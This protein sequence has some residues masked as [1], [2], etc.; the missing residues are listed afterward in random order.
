MPFIR[1]AMMIGIFG[2]LVMFA[3]FGFFGGYQYKNNIQMNGTLAQGYNSI[4]GNGSVSGNPYGIGK[5]Q[6][7]AQFTGNSLQ[8]ATLFSSLTL[9]F[10][11]LGLA[12]QFITSIPAI[13]YQLTLFVAQ[14]LVA[15]GINVGFAVAMVDLAVLFIVIISLLSALFIFPL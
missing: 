8:N 10:E 4:L 14:P 5:L 3:S 11:S 7:Q 6:T 12:G 2:L 1:S 15:I 9:T 13:F